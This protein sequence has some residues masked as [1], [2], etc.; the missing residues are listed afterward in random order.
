MKNL[1]FTSILTFFTI[2]AFGQR[3]G[4]HRISMSSGTISLSEI[5]NVE[6]TAY[7]GN[8][9]ILEGGHED[10]QV[11][12]RARGLKLVNSLGLED[13]TGIGI[14]AE[15]KNN[16]L[17]LTS[18]S[19]TS[20]DLVRIKVPRGIAIE[21]EQSTS[22]GDDIKVTGVTQELVISST[23]ANVHLQDVTGPMAI[24]TIY[25]SIEAKFDEIN[26][27]GA[28][29]LESVY[30]F[31]DVSLPS[32]TK[33]DIIL[34]TPYGEIYSDV[35]IEVS[36]DGKGMRKVSSKSIKGTVNGGGVDL[37]IKASYDNIYLRQK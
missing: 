33:A 14:S 27:D 29:Q 3:T 37:N 5:N 31:I 2:L 35:N 15:Q 30:D 26:Q 23:Y 17:Y 25:G 11:N 36:Q 22:S 21:Y 1:I 20:D 7:D 24:K 10:P 8:E 9:I 28:I 32:S 19:A 12:E 34:Q 13:N 18:I 16:T 6:I 4:E